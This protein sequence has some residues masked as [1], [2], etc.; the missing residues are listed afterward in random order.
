M[1]TKDETM[2]TKD[3]TMNTDK[4]E[5][6]LEEVNRL[7]KELSHYKNNCTIVWMIEDV[8]HCCRE[9]NYNRPSKEEGR[10]FLKYL[11][12]KHD[13]SMGISW[14]TIYLYLQWMQNEH[15]EEGEIAWP[16]EMPE[17][18]YKNEEMWGDH[19][20]NNREGVEYQ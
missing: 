18:Y 4:Y 14:D 5:V 20:L 2:N 12:R 8:E 16:C 11:E 7:R 1:N 13:A 15:R 9:M 6:L 19:P 3:E 17:D 10:A